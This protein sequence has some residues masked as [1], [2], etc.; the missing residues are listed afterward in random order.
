MSRK[1][2][3]TDRLL[4]IPADFT[5]KELVTVLSMYGFFESTKGK[6]S[7]SRVVF[8]DNK[9]NQLFVHKPH[10]GE[11]MKKTPLREIAFRL[12]QLGVIKENRDD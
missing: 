5:Y 10:P 6:T 12:L 4:S 1:K 8:T 9:G 7:G 11:I 3:L 2:K